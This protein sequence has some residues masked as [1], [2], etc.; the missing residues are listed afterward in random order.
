MIIRIEMRVRCFHRLT[1]RLALAAALLLLLVPLATRL[2]A[3]TSVTTR[4]THD[5][6]TIQA[7]SLGHG[8]D[9]PLPPAHPDHAMQPDCDYCLLLGTLD[10]SASRTPLLATTLAASAFAAVATTTPR[11]WRHPNGL[12]S[13]GPP[14]IFQRHHFA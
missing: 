2:L 10:L 5:P 1:S 6:G 11:T 14:A 3:A 4:A 12:G 7:S 9:T 13:R 8:H